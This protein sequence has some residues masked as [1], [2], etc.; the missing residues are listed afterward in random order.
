MSD[1]DR[2]IGRLREAPVPAR[3][4]TLDSA[5]ID[6]LASQPAPGSATRP[7]GMAAIAALAVGLLSSVPS[8]KVEAAPAP[9][10]LGGAA[11]LAPS[12]LLDSNQ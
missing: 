9:L 2:I 3:L 6:A 12:S 11:L 5:V 1:L 8:G 7:I 10:P 4:A